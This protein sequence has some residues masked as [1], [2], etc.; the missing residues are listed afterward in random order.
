[1]WDLSLSTDIIMRIL[2]M[3]LDITMESIIQI[4]HRT[5]LGGD[6]IT[7]AARTITDTGTTIMVGITVATTAKGSID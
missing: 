1:M 6:V 7:T 3:A 4:I 2:G 5:M